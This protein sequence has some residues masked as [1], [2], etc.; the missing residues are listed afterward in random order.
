MKST[1]R[2]NFLYSNLTKSIWYFLVLGWA[3]ARTFIVNDVFG[4]RGVNPWV[5]LVID[6]TASVPYARYTH[7]FVISY[8]EKDWNKLRI[9]AVISFITFYAPD[10][11]ILVTARKVPANIYFGFLL[12]LFIFSAVSVASIIKKIKPRSPK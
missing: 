1:R 8:L 7:S 3:L 12:I 4:G 10:I 5:Y 6:L 9:A 11:Y 2:F